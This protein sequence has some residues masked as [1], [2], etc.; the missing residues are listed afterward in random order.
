VC[1]D[2]YGWTGPWRNRRGFDSLVQMSS[3]IAAEGMRHFGTERPKPLPVQALD[4]ATGHIMAAAVLRGL[5]RRLTEGVGSGA[6]TSLA[7]TAAL[8][9]AAPTHEPAKGF[10]PPGDEDFSETIEATGWGPAKRM[11]APLTVD[12]AAMRWDYPAN[13]LGTSEPVWLSR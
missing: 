8:L 3:G 6:R 4:V 11:R 2:A 5:T 10:A 9:S 12:G 13:S 1:L 7:R